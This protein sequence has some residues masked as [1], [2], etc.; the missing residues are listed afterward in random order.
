[1]LAT[2]RT[3]AT[4]LQQPRIYLGPQQL[5]PPFPPDKGRPRGRDA[6]HEATAVA[7]RRDQNP[8]SIADVV[9]G[10]AH[11]RQGVGGFGSASVAE[12][13][14]STTAA[15]IVSENMVLFIVVWEVSASRSVWDVISYPE[16]GLADA[17]KA[18]LTWWW[19]LEYNGLRWVSSFVGEVSIDMVE[20]GSEMGGGRRER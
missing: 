8:P 10:E 13:A 11:A 2:S 18:A 3:T 20:G 12:A 7:R 4:P 1:M 9:L 17:E 15:R 6:A 5:K 16:I 19:L 14:T